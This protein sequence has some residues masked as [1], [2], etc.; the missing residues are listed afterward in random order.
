[1]PTTTY[2]ETPL[3]LCQ[4]LEEEF[5]SLHEILDQNKPR[6]EDF[7]EDDEDGAGFLPW[8]GGTGLSMRVTSAESNL[9]G[10]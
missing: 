8:S 7:V 9:P 1:M 6:A 2:T 3:H 4:V 5:E 10:G